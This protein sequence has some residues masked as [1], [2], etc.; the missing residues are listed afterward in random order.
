MITNV[1]SANT[2]LNRVNVET[3]YG[4]RSFF[5]INGD[6]LLDDGDLYIVNTYENSSGEKYGDF[7]SLIKEKYQ[8]SYLN[9]KPIYYLKDG[10]YIGLSIPK[11]RNRNP[12]LLFVHTKLKEG[13]EISKDLYES[14]IK[15][16][17]ASLASLELS[18][19]Q[20]HTISFPVLLRKGISHIYKDAASILIKNSISWLK[21]SLSTN[22]IRYYVYLKED[23]EEWNQ[24]LDGALGRKAID[25]NYDEEVSGLRNFILSLINYFPKQSILYEDTILPLQNTL[26]RENISPEIVA[27]FGRKLA[28]SLSEEMLGQQSISFNKNLKL[29]EDLQFDPLFIQTLY[30]I[31]SF[32]NSSI[33]R[34]KITYGIN[35]METE[36]LKI[37][38]III[39]KL[40]VYYQEKVWSN[41]L[42]TN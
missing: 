33:H 35:T 6:L 18:G 21:K 30:Q 25:P 41:R 2:L 7:V 1:V 24:A 17:Y 14:I 12:I 42:E 10:G 27:S 13:E 22:T 29:L 11:D 8:A 28:E 36:D 32:G 38:L 5:L 31:R 19:Y 20:F 4:D 3:N 26:M 39:K 37:L 23:A 16:I 15:G 40:I 9:D 34:S